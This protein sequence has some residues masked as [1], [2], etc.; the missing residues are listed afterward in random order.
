MLDPWVPS[1]KLRTSQDPNSHHSVHHT[2]L[3]SRF[4][5][6]PSP[7][8]LPQKPAISYSARNWT[9]AIYV[10]HQEL[11]PAISTVSRRYLTVIKIVKHHSVNEF[12]YIRLQKQT[13][14]LGKDLIA[15]EQDTLKVVNELEATKRIVNCL[16]SQLH[17]ESF[18]ANK[19]PQLLSE[20]T[21]QSP[22]SILFELKQ[23]KV[24]L[25]RTTSYLTEIRASI[26]SFNVKVDEEKS[27]LEKNREKLSSKQS[28]ISS[29]EEDLKILALNLQLAKETSV[30]GDSIKAAEFDQSKADNSEVVLSKEEYAALTPRVQ[31]ADES[32][33]KI[34]ETAMVE[35]E[36]A[37]RS[38]L[39]LVVKIEEAVEDVKIS[40]KVLK[41]ALNRLE[42][43]N[44]GKRELEEALRKCRSE[45]YSRKLDQRL[46]HLLAEDLRGE[47]KHALSIG[48]ILC[49]KL[50]DADDC[51]YDA[52]ICD[53]RDRD[54]ATAVPLGRLINRNS[55]VLSPRNG[56]GSAKKNK[57]MMIK[58]DFCSKII[59]D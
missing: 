41:E 23:A 2:R 48:E 4:L 45:Y 57:N 54:E 7:S 18:E 9:F 25:M 31:E 32:P 52:G 16:K 14:Q 43:V 11:S 33:R 15:K 35:V 49:R 26:E 34:I 58:A 37:N 36:R 13:A 5:T 46:P 10:A 6:F 1:G 24:N 40:R 42:A 21:K 30:M 22:G 53:R 59:L 47:R 50:M 19:F 17:E 56:G 39:A 38:K 29:L 20:N 27:L 55:R 44:R 12:E 51:E 3:G 28:V 8:L